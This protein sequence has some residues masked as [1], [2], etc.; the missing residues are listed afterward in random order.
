MVAPECGMHGVGPSPVNLAG[1]TPIALQLWR[2][3]QV[4]ET[5]GPSELCRSPVASVS[6]TLEEPM[7]LGWGGG[8]GRQELVSGAEAPSEGA[9]LY[10][11]WPPWPFVV[12]KRAGPAVSGS[13]LSRGT[14][15]NTFWSRTLICRSHLL[16]DC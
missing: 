3:T 15:P 5:L 6:I 1:P 11:L 14:S 9:L 16:P 10:E 7:L 8:G 13:Q 2:G 12:L 4:E